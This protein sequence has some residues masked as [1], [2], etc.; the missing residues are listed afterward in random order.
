MR[1]TCSFAEFRTK[2]RTLRFPQD[3]KIKF[4]RHTS[5]SQWTPKRITNSLRLERDAF[6]RISWDISKSVNY[7]RSLLNA[8]EYLV[9]YVK[10]EHG[11]STP[12]NSMRDIAEWSIKLIEGKKIR[13]V[14]DVRRFVNVLPRIILA[15]FHLGFLSL[16]NLQN[17]EIQ[18]LTLKLIFQT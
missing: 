18:T 12:W 11:Q 8:R 1:F 5:E 4:Q 6:P 2:D 14:S 3:I 13:K 9:G 17:I 7:A 16:S 15:V 10:I